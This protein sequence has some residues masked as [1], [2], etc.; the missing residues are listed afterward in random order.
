MLAHFIIRLVA[1]LVVL[2]GASNIPISI[3]NKSLPGAMIN[4]VLIVV[5]AFCLGCTYD[6]FDAFWNIKK[7]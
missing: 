2:T 5:I 7:T 4:F 6:D 1:F 3:A